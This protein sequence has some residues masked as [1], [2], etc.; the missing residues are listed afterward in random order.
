MPEEDVELVR[1]ALRALDQRDVGSYLS[2]AAPE[3]ELINPVR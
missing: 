1:T 3:I 2:V